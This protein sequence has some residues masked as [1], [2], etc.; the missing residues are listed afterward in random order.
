MPRMSAPFA[1]RPFAKAASLTVT[2]LD[3][4]RR[5]VLPAFDIPES[6]AGRVRAEQVAAVKRLVPVTVPAGIT[7]S[8]LLVLSFA[9]SPYLPLLVGWFMANCVL[10]TITLHGWMKA[11]QHPPRSSCGPQV[12]RRAVRNAL[13]LGGLWS[14]VALLLFPQAD[15]S[16]QV[17]LTCLVSGMLSGGAFALSPI[18][19]AALAYVAVIVP[20]A[21]MA[22]LMNAGGQLVMASLLLLVFAFFL[23][24]SVLWNSHLFVQHVLDQAKLQQAALVAALTGISNR[25]GLR[26]ALELAC[27]E[28]RDGQGFALAF[29]DLDRFKDVNDSRGHRVGDA[30][31]KTVAARLEAMLGP[32]NTIARVGG[33][34]FIVLLKGR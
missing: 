32:E 15:A 30:A 2:G 21:M 4:L 8:A 10:G 26:N 1:G 23:V 24:R 5:Q 22:L 34:E 28:A 13:V 9:D 16:R 19:Q 25:S 17:L 11:R 3:V 14:T 18:P 31:L 27:L 12:V 7:N 20:A 33:D 6:M 29:M